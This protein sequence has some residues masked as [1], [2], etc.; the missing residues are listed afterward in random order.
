[1]AK[2]KLLLAG[3]YATSAFAS[4]W[5]RNKK[6]GAEWDSTSPGGPPGGYGSTQS[7]APTSPWGYGTTSTCQA[8]T[9][10]EQHQSTVTLPGSTIT[11]HGSTATPPGS[12]VTE[13]RPASTV[14]LS[15]STVYL[16]GQASTVTLPGATY[17]STVVHT[18]A[19]SCTPI[20]PV[21]ETK[22]GPTVYVTNH[23]SCTPQAPI[24]DCAATVTKSLPGYNNTAT[25]TSVVTAPGTTV[26]T[27][28]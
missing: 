16:T 3:L 20:G 26:T 5:F 18:S 24:T 1:M 25:E 10:T 6:R 7:A 12:T 2:V 21:T 8:V 4:P 13:T 28:R 11:L 19:A 15:G 23:A 14:T 22:T 9:V 17:T 27:Y